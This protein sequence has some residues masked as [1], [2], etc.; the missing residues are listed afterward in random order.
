ME[1]Y[2]RLSVKWRV[3]GNLREVECEVE[4]G[5]KYTGG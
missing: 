1:I 3:D 5:W 2:G 4:S